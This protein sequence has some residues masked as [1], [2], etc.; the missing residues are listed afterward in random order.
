MDIIGAIAQPRDSFKCRFLAM[1][2]WFDEYLAKNP[3]IE[4]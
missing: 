2:P 1:K 4:S 3:Q